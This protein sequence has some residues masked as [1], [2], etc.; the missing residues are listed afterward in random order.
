[1][2]FKA[3]ELPALQLCKVEELVVG[4]CGYRKVWTIRPRVPS[5]A[6]HRLGTV[7]LTQGMQ[8]RWRRPLTLRRMG[9]R[10][11]GYR[12]T[13]RRHPPFLLLQHTHTA[14]PRLYPTSLHHKLQQ[15]YHRQPRR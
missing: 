2:L 11:R 14:P 12:A 7:S 15:Q 10:S 3:H 4:R 5:R 8:V 1:M 9:E 6:P 13:C